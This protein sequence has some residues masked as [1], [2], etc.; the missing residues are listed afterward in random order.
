MKRLTS[1]SRLT[2][3]RITLHRLILQPTPSLTT[4]NHDP[5]HHPVYDIVHFF[6]LGVW[7]R[8]VFVI[9]DYTCQHLFLLCSGTTQSRKLPGGTK[10]DATV[11]I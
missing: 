11:R 9:P 7:R 8:F 1:Y 6:S 10:Y 4:R 3:V 5:D 2:A